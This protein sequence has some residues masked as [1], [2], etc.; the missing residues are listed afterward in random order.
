MPNI[1]STGGGMPVGGTSG[2]VLSKNTGTDYDASWATNTANSLGS[3]VPWVSGRLYPSV[4][5]FQNGASTGAWVNNTS[6]VL[7]P[8]RIPNACTIAQAGVFTNTTA[9][10]V[11]FTVALYADSTSAASGGPAAR[12]T[13]GALA[14]TGSNYWATTLNY[15]FTAAATVWVAVGLSATSSVIYMSGKTNEG[16][17]M[18]L[19]SF[20]QNATLSPTAPYT[21]RFTTAYNYS[22]FP[23]DM[24]SV[25]T[26]LQASSFLPLVCFSIT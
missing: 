3:V 15:T 6:M 11:S 8:I 1:G 14:S 7:F 9:M 21:C 12:L 26:T 16:T 4:N 19:G 20:T 23:A 24:T 13:S 17:T 22:T 2:Q 18:F 5:Y 25:A 10:A